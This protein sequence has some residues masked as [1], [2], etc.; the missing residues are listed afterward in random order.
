MV[1][2]LLLL[3][4][5]RCD[6]MR[7]NVYLPVVFFEFVSLVKGYPSLSLSIY[8]KLVK[9]NLGHQQTGRVKFANLH[10]NH[11]PINSQNVK[12]ARFYLHLGLDCRE[13]HGGSTNSSAFECA[14][15]FG[16]VEGSLLGL[17][18]SLLKARPETSVEQHIKV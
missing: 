16:L 13:R 9:C 4:D 7:K 12:T 10:L 5:D 6:C 18:I 15:A 17:C 1:Q 3:N 8:Y 2:S 11:V 14:F